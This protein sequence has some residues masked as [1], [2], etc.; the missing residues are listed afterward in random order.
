MFIHKDTKEDRDS[1][2][3]SLQFSFL[4]IGG[5]LQFRA[6]WV[7]FYDLIHTYI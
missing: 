7:S 5:A 1:H 3:K 4:K 2:I 6:V